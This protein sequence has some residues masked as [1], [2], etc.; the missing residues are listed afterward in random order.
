MST[1]TTITP[2]P[3]TTTVATTTADTAPQSLNCYI[4]LD[5]NELISIY[6][7]KESWKNTEWYFFA[8]AYVVSCV[9]AIA[10][11]VYVAPIY[12]PITLFAANQVK[13][14]FYSA[15][16]KPRDNESRLLHE[17]VE[18]ERKILEKTTELQSITTT[19]LR[20]KLTTYGIDSRR[21]QHI[22]RLSEVSA[23]SPLRALIPL[24]ARFE[25]WKDK[26]E[27]DLQ[28]AQEQRDKAQEKLEDIETLTDFN[29][30][31][32]KRREADKHLFKAY[33]ITEEKYL[34]SKI[35][36][37]FALRFIGDI[38]SG[39][40]ME[41]FGKACLLNYHTRQMR[42]ESSENGDTPYFQKFS[43]DTDGNT[44]LSASFGRD[45][46]ANARIEQLSK[47]IFG[48]QATFCV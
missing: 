46:V 17:T 45:F 44:T 26:S 40:R 32:E 34:A 37:A 5:Q 28:A 14:P 23:D 27:T 15:V 39:V 48:N 16:L 22:T 29:K 13:Q 33:K 4:V 11:T 47:H 2:P 20:T 21:I 7:N 9:A 42:A 35:K 8:T 12:L 43:K 25:F 6:E 3:I 1:G 19:D 38:S 36:A 18:R 10:I 24:V 30:I 31:Q 41:E